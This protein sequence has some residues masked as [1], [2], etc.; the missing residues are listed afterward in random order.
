MKAINLLVNPVI[1]YSVGNLD[2]TEK[3]IKDI[4]RKTRKI[5][6]QRK[7]LHTRAEG[8]RGL[9]QIDAMHKTTVKLNNENSIKK[10]LSKFKKN[11]N[12]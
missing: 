8:G 12:I 7:A 2:W 11:E 10:N 3:A 4:D 1:V 6:T 9:R 5:L